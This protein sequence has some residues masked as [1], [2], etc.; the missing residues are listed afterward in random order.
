MPCSPVTLCRDL[1]I[2]YKFVFSAK[3]GSGCHGLLRACSESRNIM[4]SRIPL[5]LRSKAPEEI[6]FS[7]DDTLWIKGLQNLV[8]YKLLATFEG[9]HLQIPSV[10]GKVTKLG[11][12]VSSGWAERCAVSDI[13]WLSKMPFAT[14]SKFSRAWIYLCLASFRW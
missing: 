8:Y 9:A 11:I 7:S 10:F 6:R 5:R 13:S 2:E 3:R 1:R 12:F 4:V 14:S